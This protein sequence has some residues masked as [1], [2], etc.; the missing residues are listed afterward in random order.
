[1][2]LDVLPEKLPKDGVLLVDV[3]LSNHPDRLTFNRTRR[4]G[5]AGEQLRLKSGEIVGV[6]NPLWVLA[7]Q[8]KR[9]I[10]AVRLRKA[11]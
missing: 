9:P 2:T 1:L 5:T 10:P 8:P 6:A 3:Q 7:A 4:A 11:K